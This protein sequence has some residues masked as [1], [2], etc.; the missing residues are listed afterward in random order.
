MAHWY[1]CVFLLL[2]S[3][4]VAFVKKKKADQT[5]SRGW[6]DEI[7]WA[8]TYEE[9]LIKMKESN[10][11]LMVIHHLDECPYSQA[12]KKAFAESK[13]IQKMAKEDFIMLNIVHETPDANLAPDGYYVPRIIF[14]EPT[15]VVRS[16]ITGKYK[17]RKYAYEPN[18]MEFLE[19]NMIKAKRLYHT[20]L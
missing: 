15:M 12:L 13:S 6:G 18:D 11:P 19:E 3:C 5:L 8:Q 4:D 16:D 1:L 2:L 9:G 20:E 17:N 14:V 10:K 7:S